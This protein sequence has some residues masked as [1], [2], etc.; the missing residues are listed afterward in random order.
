MP[1]F[2]L[3]LLEHFSASVANTASTFLLSLA[4]TSCHSTLC[5]SAH[6][7]AARLSTPSPSL[8]R[9]HLLATTM[10][11][12]PCKAA[13]ITSLKMKKNPRVKIINSCAHKE[14]NQPTHIIPPL[15]ICKRNRIGAVINNDGA[16]CTISTQHAIT[17]HEIL[18][19][20]FSWWPW[21]SLRQRCPKLATNKVNTST[22]SKQTLTRFPSISNVRILNRY[23][24][25]TLQKRDLKSTP[26]V[27]IYCSG[28]T[29][30]QNRRTSEDFPTDLSPT[31][32]SLMRA[33]KH[34][35]KLHEHYYSTFTIHDHAQTHHNHPGE[36]PFEGLSRKMRNC[37][38]SVM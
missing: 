8:Y 26:M 3:P 38:V 17:P 5:W 11:E 34:E 6:C 23:K 36:H 28:N 1:A 27:A 7:C 22:A 12:A 9:S 21:I 10:I 33:S 35:V 30:S 2:R 24:L 4:L 15:N 25:N 29:S 20:N 18:G 37:R 32:T 31:T 16:L 19:S 13:G 14:T